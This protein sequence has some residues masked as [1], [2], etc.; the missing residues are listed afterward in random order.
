MKLKDNYED[1]S[2]GRV[3]YG[4][5]MATNFPASLSVEI[6]KR[7]SEYL[8]REGNSGPYTIYDPFCGVAYS[9]TIIGFFNGKNIKEIIASDADTTILEFAHKNLSLL[10]IKG[11]ENRIKELGVFIKEYKKNSHREALLSAEKLKKK[12]LEL[13]LVIEE[14]QFNILDN[15]QLPKVVK[16]IDMIITDLPYG[17]LTNW[18]GVDEASNPAQQFLNKVKDRLSKKSVIAVVFNKQQKV[19]YGGYTKIKAFKIGKRKVLLLKPI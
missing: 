11:I 1:Y 4:A 8:T 5:P 15:A 7:C 19:S 12:T 13:S 2:S 14:F 10:T 16:Q 18:K 3:L 6:Y 9:L 17:K